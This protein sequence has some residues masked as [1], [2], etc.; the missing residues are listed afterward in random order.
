MSGSEGDTVRTEAPEG[1]IL[2]PR[3][4]QTMLEPLNLVVLLGV[5]GGG[6]FFLACWANR[7]PPERRTKMATAPA[8][9]FIPPIIH[10][11]RRRDSPNSTLAP[12]T[13]PLDLGSGNS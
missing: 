4:R 7:V 9:S 1:R 12:I 13:L 10:P 8:P 5:A 11:S 6:G 2:D 3:L